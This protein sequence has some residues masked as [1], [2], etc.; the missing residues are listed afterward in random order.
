M[1]APTARILVTGSRHFGD[2][3]QVRDALQAAF[4]LLGAPGTITVVHGA[5]RGLD[6]I[7]AHVAQRQGMAVEAHPAQW[8]LHG[9]VAGF[10]RNQEM[11][12][13]GADICLGFPLHQRTATGKDTSRGTWHAITAATAAGIPT[14]VVWGTKLF[15]N[16]PAATGIV[17]AEQT[18]LGL[19]TGPRGEALV[20][21]LACPF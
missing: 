8:D 2:V 1:S 20:T 7:A 11:I 19:P 14:C 17:A 15:P 16:G 12:D 9:K 4:M 13:L 10:R 21:D 5:A 6:T 3:G 18:R